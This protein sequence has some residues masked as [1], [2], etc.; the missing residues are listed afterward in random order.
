M[1]PLA[2]IKIGC[3]CHVCTVTTF[4]VSVDN[5][6]PFSSVPVHRSGEISLILISGN[7]SGSYTGNK[8]NLVGEMK[9]I[10]P[11]FIFL[12]SS[13]VTLFATDGQ[14]SVTKVFVNLKVTPSLV[15]MYFTAI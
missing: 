9:N 4:G 3:I 7:H 12:L 10:L 5:S 13:L 2:Q 15:L 1:N 8:D 6:H 11:G 14:A